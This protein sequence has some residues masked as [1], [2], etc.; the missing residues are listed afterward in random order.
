VSNEWGH[1]LKGTCQ[2]TRLS[3]KQEKSCIKLLFPSY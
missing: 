3:H 1:P 2:Q